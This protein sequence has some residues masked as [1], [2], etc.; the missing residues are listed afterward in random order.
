[1]ILM[2]M[3]NTLRIW[4]RRANYSFK[5][6]KTEKGWTGGENN[7]TGCDHFYITRINQTR[8]NLVKFGVKTDKIKSSVLIGK[9]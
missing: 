4:L 2:K 1:M 9:Y 6:F 7:P 5:S 8:M 3:I